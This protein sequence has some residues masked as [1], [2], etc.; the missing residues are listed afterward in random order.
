ML[1]EEERDKS[2]RMTKEFLK[3]H[4][5]QAK[6]Y[7]TPYLNDVL[8]LHFKGFSKIENLEEYTGLRS[9]W[10]ES[11]GIGRIE[12]LDQQVELRCL[13]LHQNLIKKIE[14]I[15]HLINLDTLNLSCNRISVIENLACLPKLNTLQMTHNYLTS[16]EDI[17]HLVMCKHLSVLDLANNKL[18]DPAVMEVFKAMKNLHVLNLMGNPCIRNI[19]SYR[20]NMIVNCKMLTY[21]DDRPVFDQERACCEA[22]AI[23][24]REAEKEERE[25]WVKKEQQKITDSVNALLNMRDRKQAEKSNQEAINSGWD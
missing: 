19:D 11:N 13:Y 21:L 10:L 4:C 16:V 15:E 24:G 5:K 6:L 17:A 18:S 25:R 20:R 12:N 7:S 9:I 22:W 2:P 14:N 3:N 1:K 23:G 8:Y